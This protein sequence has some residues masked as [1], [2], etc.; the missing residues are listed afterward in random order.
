MWYA[1]SLNTITR[2]C[3]DH[4]YH[5]PDPTRALTAASLP[6]S[7][8]SKGNKT[9]HAGPIIFSCILSLPL[10]GMYIYFIAFQ[11]YV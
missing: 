7:A 4:S 1:H 5:R 2:K 8:A 11:T 6:P 3:L 10:L 9:E